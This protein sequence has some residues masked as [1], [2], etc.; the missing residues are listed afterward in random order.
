MK[1]M[2]GMHTA[3]GCMAFGV[4]E[5]GPITLLKTGGRLGILP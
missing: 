1:G 3:D 4:T 2:V 5:F